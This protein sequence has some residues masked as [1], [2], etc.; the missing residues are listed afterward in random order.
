MVSK[1]TEPNNQKKLSIRIKQIHN[2][3]KPNTRPTKN[4]I[5]YTRTQPRKQ[6][7]HIPGESKLLQR[8]PCK[9]RKETQNIQ[10]GYRVRAT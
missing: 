6:D 9:T 7:D 10:D 2:P 3:H 8:K 4:T 5:Q 1:H